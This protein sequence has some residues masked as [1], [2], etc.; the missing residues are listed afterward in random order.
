MARS[1]TPAGYSLFGNWTPAR[2]PDGRVVMRQVPPGPPI[3]GALG[4]DAKGVQSSSLAM[5]H[6]GALEPR[7]QILHKHLSSAK[8]NGPLRTVGPQT[9]IPG[10]DP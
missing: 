6:D 2:M 5:G 9:P 4:V 3:R 1:P 10:V 7:E 8:L